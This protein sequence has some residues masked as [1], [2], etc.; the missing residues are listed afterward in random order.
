MTMVRFVGTL[1]LIR[2]HMDDEGDMV[3]QKIGHLLARDTGYQSELEV[4]PSLSSFE[5]HIDSGGRKEGPLLL[6]IFSYFLSNMCL[7]VH[8]E[9]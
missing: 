5:A 8:A 9:A 6:L 2:H 3:F 1:W 4:Y 7:R